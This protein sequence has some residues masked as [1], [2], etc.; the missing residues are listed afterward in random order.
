LPVQPCNSTQTE[1]GQIGFAA[2]DPDNLGAVARNR[3][4][5]R[6]LGLA[7]LLVAALAVLASGTLWR[8]QPPHE[9]ASK[10]IDTVLILPFTSLDAGLDNDYL[11]QGVSEQVTAKL[12]KLQG[13]RLLSTEAA[14]RVKSVA[15]ALRR[16]GNG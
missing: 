13:L 9:P 12:M 5:R 3:H 10:A 15:P 1:P 4:D 16:L 8:S 11:G 7:I 2:Q 6:L 14:H